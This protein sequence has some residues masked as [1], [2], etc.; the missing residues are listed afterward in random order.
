MST[1][2]RIVFLDRAAIKSPLRSPR[3]DHEWNEYPH[4]E[5]SDIFQRVSGAEIVITNRVPITRDLLSQIPSIGLIA[6]AATGYDNVDVDACREYGVAVCNVRDWSV[7][8]PE[9]VFAL[10]LALRRNLNAYR[11]AIYAGQWQKA[12]GYGLLIGELPIALNGSVMGIIGYGGLAKRV[13]AIAKA[14]GMEVLV[15][16]RKGVESVREGRTAWRYVLGAVQVLVLL[17]PLNEETRGSIGEAELALMR[18]DALLINCARG[19]I[20]DEDAL[21]KALRDGD[22]AGAGVD[23]LREE[24]PKNGNPLLDLRIPNL[25]VTSHVAWSSVQSLQVH[26]EQLIRNI[27]AFVEGNP[28]NIVT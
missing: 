5:P 24:P 26:T 3:F 14:F 11:D 23:V 17:A 7:S 15:A 4:T 10:I 1:P 20:V 12:P 19:G 9:H 27:E 13:E 6:V 8:V 25:I 21:A 22:I 16:E 18:K 2:K 28:Q